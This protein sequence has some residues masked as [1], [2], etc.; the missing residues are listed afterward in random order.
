MIKP[1]LMHPLI[2]IDKEILLLEALVSPI[3][4]IVYD[5]VVKYNDIEELFEVLKQRRAEALKGM[6]LQYSD[7]STSL[8]NVSC[9]FFCKYVL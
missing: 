2:Q 7:M 9:E 1:Y 3:P 8:G 6:V 4:R 5:S